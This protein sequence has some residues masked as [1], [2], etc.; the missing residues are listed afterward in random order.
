VSKTSGITMATVYVT[1][2]IIDGV[3]LMMASSGRSELITSSGTSAAGL[4]PVRNG[5]TIQIFCATTVAV[6]AAAS[7]VATLA[8]G[9]ICPAGGTIYIRAKEGD[10]IA[11]IDA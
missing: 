5:D 7:P 11:V 1:Y 9:I 8:G 2:G 10:R 6:T 4:L 3:P